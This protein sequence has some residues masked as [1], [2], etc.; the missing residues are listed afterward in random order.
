MTMTNNRTTM[1]KQ[2][3]YNDNLKQQTKYN[4]KN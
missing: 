1:K 4:D 3:N 2:K